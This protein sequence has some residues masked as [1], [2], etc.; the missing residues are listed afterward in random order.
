MNKL[1]VL[2]LFSGV[3]MMDYGLEQTD[4]FETVA[5]CEIDESCQAV[6]RKHW[7]K[8]P[9]YDDIKELKINWDDNR[10]DPLWETFVRE[11]I[12]I[13]C[14]GFPCQDISVAGKQK[15]MIDEE[16]GEQT[17]SGLWN[18]YKRIIKEVGPRW[19]I[20]ENV[21]NLRNKGLATLIK[22]LSELGYVG[23]AEPISARAVGA[24]HLR[25]RYWIVARLADSECFRSRRIQSGRSSGENW[26]EEIR[27]GGNGEIGSV[28]NSYESR[29][30]EQ[31][32]PIG[33]QPEQSAVEC[34]RSKPSNTECIYRLWGA[35][36]SE[37]EKSKWWTEAA[38]RFGNVFG[39]ITKI[40]PTICRNNDG[41][42][43]E[44]DTDRRRAR[45]VRRLEQLRKARIKQLGNGLIPQIA[46]LIGERILDYERKSNSNNE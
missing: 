33:I 39:Q 18:E 37:E 5:F 16:T 9:V 45:I 10:G 36:K 4:G 25:K 41:N 13:I 28:T 2:S 11:G 23:F 26:P 38:S 35:Y 15:G 34:G 6:L 8:V 3:G 29:L 19:V 31:C 24:C 40:K 1:K 46:Q 21:F 30:E 14:G 22:D 20:I 7:P 32:Q 27:I 17:R 42:T 12:D 43:F 44:L